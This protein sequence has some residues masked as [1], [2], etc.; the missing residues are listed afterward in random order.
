MRRALCHHITGELKRCLA[1]PHLLV[2]LRLQTKQSVH[3]IGLKQRTSKRQTQPL[4][5]QPKTINKTK[6]RNNNQQNQTHFAHGCKPAT[7]GWLSALKSGAAAA[8]AKEIP[9]LILVN[10]PSRRAEPKNFPLHIHFQKESDRGSSPGDLSRNTIFLCAGKGE[11]K[12]SHEYKRF[13]IVRQSGGE[14]LP[15]RLRKPNFN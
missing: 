9:A 15:R 8:W 5:F 3:W 2:L 14:R 10:G 6:E 13:D 7:L 11:S 4:Q 1:L 12:W